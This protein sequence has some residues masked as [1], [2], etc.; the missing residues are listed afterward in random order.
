MAKI[1]RV[2][3]DTCVA[4]KQVFQNIH[5]TKLCPSCLKK[6]EERFDSVRTYI[7][8]NEDV[9]VGEVSEAC[10]VPKGQIL[11]WVREERLYF[12][13]NSDVGV[14]CLKCGKSINTGKFCDQCRTQVKSDLKGAYVETSDA[15]VDRQSNGNKMHF[16]NKDKR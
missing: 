11:K 15:F 1:N 6:M 5:H 16:L 7:K 9:G 8:E 13:S 10:H 4:C 14:P 2:K 12:S 3:I